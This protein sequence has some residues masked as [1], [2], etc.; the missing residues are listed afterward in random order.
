MKKSFLLLFSIF[1][2]HGVVQ[3]ADKIRIAVPEP[4]AAY[5]TFPLAHKIGFLTEQGFAAEVYFDARHSHDAGAKQRRYRLS[6][7]HSALASE[8]PSEGSRSK[9]L[10]VISRGPVLWWLA[11]P[12]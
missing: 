2:L 4:N 5:L 12:T 3:A 9:S 11:A 8:G 1:V 10:R 7:S 6:D